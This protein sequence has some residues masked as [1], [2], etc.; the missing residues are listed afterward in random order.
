MPSKSADSSLMADGGDYLLL[1]RVLV[2]YNPIIL[3]KVYQK[4]NYS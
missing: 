1:V 4:G 3:Y 2:L